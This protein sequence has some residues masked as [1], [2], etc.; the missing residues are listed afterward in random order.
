MKLFAAPNQ[1]L[2]LKPHLPWIVRCSLNFASAAKLGDGCILPFELSELPWRGFF[3]GE[4]NVSQLLLISRLV[5]LERFFFWGELNDS[6][7]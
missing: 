1:K 3:W 5:T 4:L 6:R 7:Y 2:I